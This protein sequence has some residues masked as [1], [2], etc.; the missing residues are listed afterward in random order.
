MNIGEVHDALAANR[1]LIA[2]TWEFF[3][4]VHIALFGLVFIIDPRRVTL[5]ARAFM[6]VAYFGFLYLNYRA[7]IDNYIYSRELIELGVS[8]ERAQGGATQGVL[9]I[10][11]HAGW[12]LAYLHYVY[13]GV[14]VCGAALLAFPHRPREGA[15]SPAP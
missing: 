14:A 7:Q 11:F 2:S 8:L 1:A 15:A 12:V 5:L 3:V 4:S 6:L 9:G 10:A 13:A